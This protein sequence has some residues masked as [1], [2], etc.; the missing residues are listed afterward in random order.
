MTERLSKRLLS[1]PPATERRWEIDPAERAEAAKRL[2]AAHAAEH[3]GEDVDDAIEWAYAMLPTSANAV[4]LKVRALLDHGDTTNA[5][6]I[7]AQALLIRPLHPALAALRAEAL[8]LD[9]D[10]DRAL[11]EIRLVVSR[12]AHHGASLRL[13]AAIAHAAGHE[14]LALH[15]LQRAMMYH[16]TNDAIRADLIDMYLAC[17][18]VPAAASQLHRLGRDDVVLRARVLEAQGRHADARYVLEAAL[19]DPQSSSTRRAYMALLEL[20]QRHGDLPRLAA[21]VDDC[22]VEHDPAIDLAMA[23]A[24]LSLGHFGETLRLAEPYVLQPMYRRAALRCVIVATAM[25]GRT[26]RARAAIGDLYRAS[27]DPE[28]AA[29]AELWRCAW[30]GA[31]ITDPAGSRQSG[32]DPQTSVLQP[33]LTN[34]IDALDHALATDS[35]LGAIERT[36]YNAHRSVCLAAAGRAHEI[37]PVSEGD[38][39]AVLDRIEPAARDRTT[40]N[41][42]AA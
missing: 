26:D 34:T 37:T 21:L 22:P 19:D 13:G 20:V 30:L 38:D 36:R 23:T 25:T 24:H 17:N 18:D 41:R 33:L 10:H 42:K 2:R 32:A 15:W 39:R 14:A 3:R 16:P 5:R 12:R 28:G 27:L 8:H 35:T 6:P 1:T 4:R 7:L 40:S 31:A 9:G 29:L 11:R